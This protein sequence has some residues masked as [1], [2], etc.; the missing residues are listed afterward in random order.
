MRRRIALLAT[1]LLMAAAPAAIAA[2]PTSVDPSTLTPPPN[3]NFTWT[4]LRYPTGIECTGVEPSGAVDA[5][6]DPAFS[7][8]GEPILVTF[9]QLLTSRRSHDADGRVTR[10]HVVGTFDEQ[11]RLD[12]TGGPVLTSRGRWTETVTFAIPGDPT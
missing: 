5:S 4:C 12:R 8:D 3:P 1:S 6:G 2:G 11:W 9:T 7:C 10:N